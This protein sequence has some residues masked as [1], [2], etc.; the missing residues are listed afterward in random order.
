MPVPFHT[1]SYDISVFTVAAPDIFKEI[2]LFRD[3][4]RRPPE[5][6]AFSILVNRFL[7]QVS[8]RIL[9]FQRKPKRLR[10]RRM[11]QA[12]LWIGVE[13][14]PSAAVVAAA[15]IQISLQIDILT[16]Q[17]IAKTENP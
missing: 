3:R 2:I 4:M 17:Q 13:C 7:D 8:G 14:A 5:E 12:S 11:W 15:V 16:E 6:A 9:V 10:Q 1:L